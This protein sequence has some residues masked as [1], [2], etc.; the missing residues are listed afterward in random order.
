MHE[1]LI[2]SPTEE[3]LHHSHFR[4]LLPG[5]IQTNLGPLDPRLPFPIY[6]QLTLEQ[7][8]IIKLR[9]EIGWNHQGIEK[10]LEHVS[11]EEG[12]QII[13]RVNFLCP[14]LLENQF[15]I[16]CNLELLDEQILKTEKKTYHLYFIREI[17]KLLKED[18]LLKHSEKDF[19]RF[20]EKFLSSTKLKKRLSGIGVISLQQA[21]S[22]GLTGPSLKACYEPYTG[23][24]WSRLVIKLDEISDPSSNNHPEGFLNITRIGN[25]V[26]IRTPAF[27]HAA[28]LSIF[29][30]DANL[31]DLVLILLSL[32][33]VG[34]E[35]D[36]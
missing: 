11:P 5:Q 29:L 6:F 18:R 1:E 3:E 17:L 10:L 25:R 7:R 23:D 24:I 31:N 16:A 8:Q 4:G 19:E 20:K 34:T 36:R 26:R 22:F 28:A 21:L 35:I 30:K 15:R 2:L 32:G 33:L 9:T 14:N 13:R 12:C 27:A